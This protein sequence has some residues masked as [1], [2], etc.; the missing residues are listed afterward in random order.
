MQYRKEHKHEF[1][2]DWIH[3]ETGTKYDKDWYDWEWYSC[4]WFNKLGINRFW[5]DMMWKN[6]EPFYDYD[7]DESRERRREKQKE[8]RDDEKLRKNRKKTRQQNPRA[9]APVSYENK[10]RSLESKVKDLRQSYI[11]VNNN[12]RFSPYKKQQKL[13]EIHQEAKS[14]NTTIEFY[15]KYFINK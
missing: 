1:D 14:I 5:F 10:I 2:E 6:T 12:S 7:R 8:I 15:K 11:N 9:T 4:I 13:K 3:K